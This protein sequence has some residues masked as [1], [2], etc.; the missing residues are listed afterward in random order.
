MSA[1]ARLPR[2]HE[3]DDRKDAPVWIAPALRAADALEAIGLSDSA[4]HVRQS[5]TY[6]GGTDASYVRSTV[7]NAEYD[8]EQARCAIR[9]LARA[10]LEPVELARD[11]LA[12]AALSAGGVPRDVWLASLNGEPERELQGAAE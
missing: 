9:A 2:V 7:R 6:L 10:R 5:A 11:L 12:E 3:D 8:V 1:P 4:W